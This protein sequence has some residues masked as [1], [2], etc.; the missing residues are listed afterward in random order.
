MSTIKYGDVVTADL[1]LEGENL[2]EK[3][4]KRRQAAEEKLHK[5]NVVPEE[6]QSKQNTKT[7]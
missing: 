4:R 3:L 1:T 5:S 7:E 6:Q 2:E